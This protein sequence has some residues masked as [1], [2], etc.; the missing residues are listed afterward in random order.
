[1]IVRNTQRNRKVC[2]SLTM[3]LYWKL[4]NLRVPVAINLSFSFGWLSEVGC[5]LQLPSSGMLYKDEVCRSNWSI[6]SANTLT[7][8]ELV[9]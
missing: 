7:F 9:D 2:R 6:P 5:E 4:G 3:I 8:Q 1:M